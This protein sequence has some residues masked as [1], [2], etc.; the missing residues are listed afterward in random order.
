M[1]KSLIAALALMFSASFTSGYFASRASLPSCKDYAARN[2]L[3]LVESVHYPDHVVCIYLDVPVYRT[4]LPLQY[5]KLYR[6]D[7]QWLEKILS[8]HTSNT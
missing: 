8:L 3:A 5:K 2:Q 6:N 1:N 4:H 7:A